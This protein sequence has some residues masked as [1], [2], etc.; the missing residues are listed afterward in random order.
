MT[1]RTTVLLFVACATACATRP[2][3]DSARPAISLQASEAG[4]QWKERLDES[5]AYTQI[6]GDRRAVL[7][8]VARLHGD[9]L[10]SDAAISGPP[11]V[12]RP[13]DGAASASETVRVCFPIDAS[14][15]VPEGLAVDVL[16]ASMVVYA[17]VAGRYDTEV[18]DPSDLFSFAARMNWR[19]AGPMREI[20]LVPPRSADVESLVREIQIP[21]CP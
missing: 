20:F 6:V 7:A 19:V 3:S 16:P 4:P 18:V 5:Y 12:L 9:L 14:Q 21:T 2:T 10:R 17:R 15:A 11:F 1:Q 13:A 8:E